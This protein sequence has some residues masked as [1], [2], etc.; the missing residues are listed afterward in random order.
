MYDSE[1]QPKKSS[2]Q[3]QNLNRFDWEKA[4]KNE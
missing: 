1:T 4:I 3:K 2:L